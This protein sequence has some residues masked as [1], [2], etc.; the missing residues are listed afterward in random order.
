MNRPYPTSRN[1]ITPRLIPELQSLTLKLE[2][3]DQRLV[4]VFYHPHLFQL[5]IRSS[6]YL[7]SLFHTRFQ[8]FICFRG[9]FL[10]RYQRWYS[11][12]I[13]YYHLPTCP[14]YTFSSFH[15]LFFT[16][17]RFPRLYEKLPG[18]LFPALP[19]LLFWLCS[20]A[21]SP[22]F[23]SLLVY[24]LLQLLPLYYINRTFRLVS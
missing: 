1:S 6:I 7:Y 8:I 21:H 14:A 13:R 22:A 24:F 11:R 23:H 19:F 3:S 5:G 10:S 12:G 2:T 20:L 4:T 17:Y 15:L 9:N 18:A 16:V